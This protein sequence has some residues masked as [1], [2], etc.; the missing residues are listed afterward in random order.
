MLTVVRCSVL[1]GVWFVDRRFFVVRCLLLVVC[2]LMFDVCWFG[3]CCFLVFA[4]VVCFVT[5][6]GC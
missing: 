5:L 1:V 4:V 6:V 2:C 3:V